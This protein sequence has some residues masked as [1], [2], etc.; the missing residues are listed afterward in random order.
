M[1]FMFPLREGL[2]SLV[3]INNSDVAAAPAAPAALPADELSRESRA[4][5]MAPWV[6]LAVAIGGVVTP[7]AE[8]K[9]AFGHAGQES[10]EDIWRGSGFQDF[11]TKLMRDERDDRCRK[12]YEIEEA[13]GVSLRRHFNTNFTRHAGRV[14][15]D[16]DGSGVVA[17]PLPVSLDVRFSNLCNFSCRM[18]WYGSSSKWF[19]D[20][21]ELGWNTGPSALIASFPTAAEGVRALRPL[22]ATVEEIYWAGGE[23]LLIEEHYA[24]LEELMALG[25]DRV[26]LKYNSNLSKLNLGRFDVLALWG[27]FKNVTLEVSIDGA[28]RRGELI[29][30]GLSWAQLLEN[31]AAVKKRCPHVRIQFGITVSVFN[32]FAL[33]ELHRE[34][35]TLGCGGPRNIGMHVLQEMAYYNIQILPSRLKRKIARR[36]MVYARMLPAGENGSAISNS[37]QH[38]FHHVIDYMMAAD[39]QELIRQFRTVTLQLD[40]LRGQETGKI[41]PELAPLLRISVLA[42]LRRQAGELLRC[43]TRLGR[44]RD[45][46]NPQKRR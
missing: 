14:R 8:A 29:R 27:W 4:F 23:P 28:G 13:G 15:M 33:P 32:V 45:G 43:I 30:H 10:I 1:C 2:L 21:R 35:L 42:R 38:Q 31:I 26:V 22:L 40:R 41:C 39:R 36:L 19:S 16:A 34:L 24:V 25:R 46:E 17:P 44:P 37:G 3:E 7:C 9:G 18:C 6:H 20:A 5:C 11:R 12:C